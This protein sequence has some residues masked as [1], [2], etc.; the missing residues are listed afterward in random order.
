MFVS[1]LAVDGFALVEA[2]VE[3]IWPQKEVAWEFVDLFYW[4]AVEQGTL[5]CWMC[6]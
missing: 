3:L 4:V 2:V 5:P 6:S 1:H